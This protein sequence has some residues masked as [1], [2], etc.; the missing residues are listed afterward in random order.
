MPAAVRAGVD[1]LIVTPSALVPAFDTFVFWRTRLGLRTDVVAIESIQACVPGRD[2]PERLRNFIRICRDSLGTQWVLLAGSIDLIPVRVAYT[3]GNLTDFSPCDLYFS[4]LDGTWD[5]DNDSIFGEE[6]DSVDLYADVFVGRAPVASIAEARAVANKWIRMDREPAPSYLTKLLQVGDTS[7]LGAPSS[8][9]V[10]R[11]MP[12]LGR[13]QFRDSLEAGFQLVWHVGHATRAVLMAGA[14]TILD[15]FDALALENPDRLAVLVS[16]GSEVAAFDGGCIGSCLL[17][18]PNGGCALVLGNT[19]AGW[20]ACTPLYTRFFASLFSSE[21]LLVAGRNFARTK[22]Y[23]VPL[24][25][26]NRYWRQ[27]LYVW[28]LLGDPALRL[29]NDTVGTLAVMHPAVIDTGEQDFPVVVASGGMPRWALVCLWKGNEVYERCWVDGRGWIPIHPRTSGEML[30]T[31]TAANHL[32]Y[33][34]TCGVATGL[35]DM[36]GTRSRHLSATMVSGILWLP[37]ADGANA[38]GILLDVT[39]R[40]VRDLVPGANDVRLLAPGV[41]FVEQ[42]EAGFS[43]AKGMC[44]RVVVMR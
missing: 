40:K 16:V 18:N 25:R 13:Y 39:G 17:R 29:W 7:N 43:E 22:D 10:A 30:V 42:K 21:T 38:G 1:Y 44:N 26:T 4:D 15:S 37:E 11:L 41:Y 20:I 31:V 35:S 34:G 6:S 27:S 2:S 24:A 36:T 23:F 33:T 32:P 12:P 5:A 8:W 14:Q 28:S 3:P 19:R 9:F